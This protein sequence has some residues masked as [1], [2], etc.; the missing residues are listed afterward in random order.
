MPSEASSQ[1][2]Y[3]PEPAEELA[4]VVSFL[5]AHEAR[6]GDSVRPRYLLVGADEHDQV[7]LPES[8]HRVLVQVVS[9]LRDGKAVTVAPQSM[10]LTTQQAADLLGVSRPTVVRLIDANKI[11][12][13]RTGSRRRLL[14]TDVL[15]YREQ[16]RHRQYE[17]LAATA[18]GLDDE[19]DPAAVL[20]ELREI[21]KEAARKRRG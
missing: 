12:A 13:E 9:A 14:L 17:A 4:P 8:L 6:H 1:H 11:P 2:T 7:E 18:F 5:A 16:R 20:A 15:A 21:R 19:E 3:L 10:T